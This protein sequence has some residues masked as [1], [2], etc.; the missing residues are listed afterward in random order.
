MESEN[1]TLSTEQSLAIITNMIRQAKGNVKRNSIYLILWGTTS[2]VANLGMFILMLMDYQKPH[3]VWLIT[4]PAWIATIYISYKYSREETMSSHLDRIN[5]FLW[6]SYGIILLAI[7]A[8]GYKINYQINPI[9][10]LISAVPAFVSGTI[11]KFRPLALGGILFGVFGIACFLVDGPWQYLIGAIAV[12]TGH[13]VPGLVLRNKTDR[14][15][16]QRT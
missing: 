5:A 7:V 6:Y 8:F 11:I 4:V 15:D 14:Q 1:Q 12:T 9:V 10:L 13:L 3:V 16:V 2:A